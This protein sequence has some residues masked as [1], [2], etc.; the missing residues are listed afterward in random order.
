[1]MN[2]RT[3]LKQG[4]NLL[5]FLL[6]FI[7]LAQVTLTGKVADKTGEAI[8]FANVILKNSEGAIT[9]GSITAEDGT[10]KITTAAG[11]YTLSVTF[12]GY[13]NYEKEIT[14]NANQQLDTIVLEDG[15]ELDEVVV[16]ARKSLIRR[17]VDRLV[18][19]IENSVSA[20][21]GTAVDALKVSPGVAVSGDQITMIGKSGMRAMVDGR[22]ILLNGEELMSFLASIPA[23]DIKEIEIIT[24][25]PAK[26]EAEGNSGLINIIYKKGRKNSWSNRTSATYFQAELPRYTLRNNFSYQKDKV[27]L[28]FSVNGTTGNTIIDREGEIRYPDG[29]WIINRKDKWNNADLSGRLL[30]DYNIS[31]RSTIGFQY[32]G[33]V[34][35][36]DPSQVTRSSTEIYNTMG[37]IDSLLNNFGRSRQEKNTHSLNAHF[38][39]ELD[40]LGK[41]MSVDVD[42][43]N[44]N[45]D[46]ERDVETQSFL[47]NNTLLGTIFSNFNNNVQGVD[48]LSARVDFEHPLK[49]VS[50]SYGAKASFTKSTYKTDNFNTITGVPVLDTNVSDDFEYTENVQSLYINASKQFNDKWSMQ[51]GLRLENTQTEGVSNILNQTNTNDYARLFPTFY[52]SYNANEKNNFSFNYGRRISRPLYYQLNPARTYIS[53]VN[54]IEGNP[55][56]QP[57]FTHNFELSHVFNRKL[58]TTLFLSIENDGFGEIADIDP[59]TNE[60]FFVHQNFFTHYNYGISQFYTFDK[61]SWWESQNSLYL[62]GNN[63]DLDIQDGITAQVQNGMRFYAS[64]YNTFN[65]NSD[66]TIRGL[67]DF[68]YSSPYKNNLYDYGVSYEL[69]LALKIDMMQRN[70]QLSMGVYDIFNTSPRR[71]SSFTNGIEQIQTMFPSNRNFRITLTYNT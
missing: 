33:S 71:T 42:Y 21:G 44:Y 10:F 20:I 4:S 60:Q 67:I 7:S 54:F 13:K 19:N 29:Q 52:L 26:Y 68:W 49:A 56:L 46:S 32:L 23:D 18:Y 47:T 57:S 53:N 69:D 35:N 37:S 62:I 12:I 15:D 3:V 61:V 28:I 51:F 38:K 45:S 66:K 17:K 58:V 59:A 65:L 63:T 41:N 16:E 55:Q 14:L 43:F 8:P 48:N 1:M 50:L 36:P 11:T 2:S 27:S 40:T 22:I 9:G 34:S 25:P 31:D 6:P 30:F 70:L 64:S 24:N 5:F 39:T